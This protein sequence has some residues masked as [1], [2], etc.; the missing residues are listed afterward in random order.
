M[1]VGVQAGK[2]HAT[3]TS[4]T[5]PWFYGSVVTLPNGEVIQVAET[6]DGSIL[7]RAFGTGP[8]GTPGATVTANADLEANVYETS[9]HATDGRR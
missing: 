6:W 3:L 8:V 1:A 4:Q 7:K 9:A 5:K 2:S